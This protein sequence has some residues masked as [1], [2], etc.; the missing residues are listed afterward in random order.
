MHDI[1]VIIILSSLDD[2]LIMAKYH[3]YFNKIQTIPIRLI[4]KYL[5]YNMRYLITDPLHY[6]YNIYTTNT[7]I[8]IGTIRYLERLEVKFLTDLSH[9]YPKAVFHRRIIIN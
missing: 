2:Y 8:K 3:N 1:I 9:F 7:Y 6:C 4:L 5:F